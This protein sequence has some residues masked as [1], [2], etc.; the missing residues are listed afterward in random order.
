M[1]ALAPPPPLPWLAGTEMID[2]NEQIVQ[3]GG[4]TEIID[5]NKVIKLTGGITYLCCLY[6]W[7]GK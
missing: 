7:V 4:T 5:V 6:I 2:G 3:I 1:A